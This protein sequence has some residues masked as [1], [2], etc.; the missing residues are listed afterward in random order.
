MYVDVCSQPN[1]INFI[2]IIFLL[3][4]VYLIVISLLV[5]QKYEL[6]AKII[7]I[8]INKFKIHHMYIIYFNVYS[9]R[10]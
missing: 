8:I 6:Q 7:L 9:N 2:L 10:K 4:H 1:Y 5:V 3:S